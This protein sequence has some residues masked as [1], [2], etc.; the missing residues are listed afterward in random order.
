MCS[1]GEEYMLLTNLKCQVSAKIIKVNADDSL[2]RRLYD[3]GF[4][5]GNNVKC[6][7]RS[8]FSSPIL[9]Q[10]NGAL[11]ALRKNDANEIEV[12]YEE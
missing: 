7:L 3:L 1:F 6:I 4:F 11:I 5:P 10:V 9:Y 8:P 12:N 2:K